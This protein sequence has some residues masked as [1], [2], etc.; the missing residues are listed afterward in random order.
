[1]KLQQPQQC[2]ITFTSRQIR[3]Q[4]HLQNTQNTFKT[5][6][7]KTQNLTKGKKH[8]EN[9]F[10]VL[11]HGS[12]CSSSTR[13]KKCHHFCCTNINTTTNT[14]A[15]KSSAI[16]NSSSSNCI[17]N[18]QKILSS[19]S[20]SNTNKYPLMP[21]PKNH[22]KPKLIQLCSEVRIVVKRYFHQKLLF[23]NCEVII[24]FCLSLFHQQV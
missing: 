20:R 4:Q 13:N 8:S 12:F 5:T 9:V 10:W 15:H 14:H 16:Y 1:M 18:I 23:F 19:A 22:Q 21:Q 17:F 11:V 7:N 3:Q 2:E 6:T 24:I